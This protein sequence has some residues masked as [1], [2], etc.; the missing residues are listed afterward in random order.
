MEYGPVAS[1]LPSSHVSFLCSTQTLH[2][3]EEIEMRTHHEVTLVTSASSGRSLLAERSI[4]VVFLRLFTIEC[5]RTVITLVIYTLVVAHCD[6][7]FLR[8][9]HC[10]PLPSPPCWSV[11]GTFTFSYFLS[12]LFSPYS[13]NTCLS[14]AY[15]NPSPGLANRR[16]SKSIFSL[17]FSFS[18]SCL[19]A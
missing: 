15:R 13:S 17:P 10:S 11:A 4:A 6:A 18:C 19:T 2:G 1:S 7:K 12:P 5:R 16:E 8:F 14:L 3:L 9:E